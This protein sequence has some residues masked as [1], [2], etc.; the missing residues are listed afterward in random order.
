MEDIKY[1]PFENPQE[2]SSFLHQMF[3][4]YWSLQ[5]DLFLFSWLQMTQDVKVVCK[6][7]TEQEVIF[8]IPQSVE[9]GIQNNSIINDPRKAQ[10]GPPV[11]Y[12]WTGWTQARIH[13]TA[14]H[15]P[16]TKVG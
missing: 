10:L 2:F 11:S 15:C 12:S 5:D 8:P 13:E 3:R 9:R 16:T 7:T 1:D 4:Y 6:E 14:A